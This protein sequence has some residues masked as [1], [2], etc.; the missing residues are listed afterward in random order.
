LPSGH[1]ASRAAGE[2]FRARYLDP[3][4]CAAA[5]TC[6][7]SST[8][9]GGGTGYG[10]V[11][12]PGA[13]FN[14]YNAL[15]RSSALDRT[16]S[17]AY[18]FL[19]GVFPGS[20]NSSG[21]ATTTAAVPVPVYPAAGSDADDWLVRA[22][23]KCPAYEQRLKQWFTSPEFAAKSAETKSTRAA[24]AAAA[25][26]TDVALENWWNGARVAVAWRWWCVFL[27]TARGWWWWCVC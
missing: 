6:L 22:Y 7:A 20:S 2:A 3:A 24:V 21:N 23:T 8:D 15:A 12:A 10:L 17:S 9:S 13:G 27:V 4:T 11:G 14:N 18:G 19:G 1:A 25:P 5:G 26:G 16:L